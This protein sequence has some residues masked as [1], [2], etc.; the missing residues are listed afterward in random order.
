MG[1]QCMLKKQTNQQHCQQQHDQPTI[2]VIQ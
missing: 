2:S 1:K